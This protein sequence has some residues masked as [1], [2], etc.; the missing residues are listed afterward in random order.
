MLGNCAGMTIRQLITCLENK[1]NRFGAFPLNFWY[2]KK[3]ADYFAS[4][5]HADWSFKEV[6]KSWCVLLLGLYLAR[7]ACVSLIEGSL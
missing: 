1:K 7:G 2:T 3:V 6:M 4:L 5:L